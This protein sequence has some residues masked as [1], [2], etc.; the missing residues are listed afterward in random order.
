MQNHKIRLRIDGSTLTGNF[1][2][3]NHDV[4]IGKLEPQALKEFGLSLIKLDGMKSVGN[5]SSH[6]P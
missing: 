4:L 5:A 3:R 2:T 1:Q 6:R